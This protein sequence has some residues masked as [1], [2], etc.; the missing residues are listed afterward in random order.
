ML[1]MPIP[2]ISAV[3][4]NCPLHALTPELL[5]EIRL[6]SNKTLNL[7]L[8]LRANYSIL[9]ATFVAFYHMEGGLTWTAFYELLAAQNPFDLQLILG[10]VL[11]KVMQIMMRQDQG[12]VAIAQAADEHFAGASIEGFI[13]YK[14]ELQ[15]DGRY[16]SLSPDEVFAFLAKHLGFDMVVHKDSSKYRLNMG[17]TD[18]SHPRTRINLYH[19]GGIEGAAAGG[20]FERSASL[21]DSVDFTHTDHHP[22]LNIVANIFR[23]DTPNDTALG[24]RLLRLYIA[25]AI[26]IQDTASSTS[27]KMLLST[28]HLTVAQ[29]EKFLFNIHYVDRR[30]AITLLGGLTVDAADII[31]SIPPTLVDFNL[32]ANLS[33]LISHYYPYFEEYSDPLKPQIDNNT[34]SLALTLMTP[35]VPQYQSHTANDEETWVLRGNEISALARVTN[36]YV[37]FI[38]FNE[39]FSNH[40]YEL[41]NKKEIANELS[42]EFL[43]ILRQDENF[44]NK[45]S[46][47]LKSR[48]VSQSLSDIWSPKRGNDSDSESET[49]S[50]IKITRSLFQNV[51]DD[52][53]N[54]EVSSDDEEIGNP[55][56]RNKARGTLSS[57]LPTFKT[58]ASRSLYDMNDDSENDEVSSN[59]EEINNPMARKIKALPQ[60]RVAPNSAPPAEIHSDFWWKVIQGC[61]AVGGICGVIALLTC[62]PVAAALGVSK[63]AGIATTDIAVSATF[64]AGTSA[65]LA[66]SLF[67]IRKIFDQPEVA[68]PANGPSCSG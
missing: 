50:E 63:I 9:K 53:E 29:I 23:N 59:D 54:D 2:R 44:E 31:D 52:S 38:L 46:S 13:Q 56:A 3:L 20:H 55:M 41:C 62:S 45:A 27:K 68:R 14:T 47:F 24:L 16:A 33:R 32:D 8:A 51:D 12:A 5:E 6:L 36:G 1:P 25:T 35:P 30:M 26:K 34:Y 49:G 61:L 4:N 15:A 66:G 28:F 48:V 11:R 39:G 37:E 42:H 60:E 19:Q 21:A 65:L 17:S 43:T 10:P 40:L 18:A 7:T 64:L 22:H 58:N 67:A 57:A